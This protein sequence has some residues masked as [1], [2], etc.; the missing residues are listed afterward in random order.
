MHGHSGFSLLSSSQGSMHS[1]G[2]ALR[3][4]YALPSSATF[5]P[6]FL[7]HIQRHCCAW[8]STSVFRVHAIIGCNESGKRVFFSDISCILGARF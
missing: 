7:C 4:K 1:N 5:Q 3:P 2:T 8:Y 6:N